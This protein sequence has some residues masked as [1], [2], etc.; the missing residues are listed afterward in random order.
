MA[1]DHDIVLNFAA[2]THVDR[3]IA[4]ASDFVAANVAGVQVLL[5]ACLDAGVRRV[6]QVSTDEVY[7][8]VARGSWSEDAPLAPNSPYAAARPAGTSWPAPTSGPM[9]SMSS[10]RGASTTTVRTSSPRRSS[11]SSPPTS[12]TGGQVPLYGDGGNVRGW[13]HVDDHCRGIQLALERG[14]GG[15]VYHIGGGTRS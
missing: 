14:Q 1:Q 9:G 4:G 2:E 6:V 11:R 10:S 5:Q 3:S 15:G 7:G 13:I 8:S 12:S